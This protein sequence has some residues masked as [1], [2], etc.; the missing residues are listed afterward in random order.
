MKIIFSLLICL[1]VNLCLAQV[2]YREITNYIELKSLQSQIDEFSY[3]ISCDS[4]HMMA[5]ANPENTDLSI[6]CMEETEGGML[7]FGK[8]SNKIFDADNNAFIQKVMFNEFEG[9]L[10]L[11]S[12]SVSSTA[13]L[14]LLYI[15]YYSQ[16]NTLPQPKAFLY[17][18]KEKA[19]E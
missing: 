10:E 9:K 4:C 16:P 2:D 18:R 3:E 19:A 12:L 14:T 15:N 5:T 11:Q 7:V 13:E 8:E 1:L 17:K 6:T